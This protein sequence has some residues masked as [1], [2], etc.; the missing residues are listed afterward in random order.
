MIHIK[1]KTL[2]KWSRTGVKGPHPELVGLRTIQSL[3]GDKDTQPTLQGVT[4]T[5]SS[6]LSTYYVS[7]TCQYWRLGHRFH[8]IGCGWARRRPK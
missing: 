2:K 1:K 7:A 6:F 3:G 8:K 5:S 4:Y